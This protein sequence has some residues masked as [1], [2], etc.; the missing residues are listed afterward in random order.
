LPIR[1]DYP[2]RHVPFKLPRDKPS[3]DDR[4]RHVYPSVRHTALRLPFRRPVDR[5][6]P[7]RVST[8]ATSVVQPRRP[9]PTAGDTSS[10]ALRAA[11]DKSSRPAPLLRD[12]QCPA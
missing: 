11:C 12:W 6:K 10:P 3:A 1:S 5:D 4:E 2:T 9:R 7:A 8:T